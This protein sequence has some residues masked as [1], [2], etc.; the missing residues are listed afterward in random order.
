MANCCFLVECSSFSSLQQ[1][2]LDLVQT[3]HFEKESITY[4][5]LE[6]NTLEQVL[7]DLD[8]YS[9]LTPRKVVVITKALF[10]TVSEVKFDEKEIE[11]ILKYLKTPSSDVLFIMGIDKCDERKKIVKE[12]KKLVQVVKVEERPSVV[13]KK[14]LYDYR[15]TDEALQ[16]LLEFTVND[17]IRLTNEC[18]K[19][20]LYTLESKQITK[21]D[22]L[23]VVIKNIPNIEQLSFDFVKYLANRDKKK[24]FECYEIL[25]EY[26]FEPHSMIG[27]I[28]SQIKLIYQV[29]LGKR[30]NMTKDE[31]AKYL[32]EHPFRVQKT[33]EFLP[34]YQEEEL[35]KIIHELHDLDYRIKSGVVDAT[36]GFELFLIY[37]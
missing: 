37:I 14:L 21:E 6:E 33:L 4:Y 25:K 23:T 20:K 16:L 30:K 22:V 27:L 11:H 31:I 15:I 2:V 24:L 13:A 7:E 19:L 12:V 35:Q 36:S 10:L 9:F 17:I 5:D 3:T 18:E 8:T 26:K 28:E 1:K 29:L 32:K 34:L